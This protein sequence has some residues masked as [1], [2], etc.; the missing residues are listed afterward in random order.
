LTRTGALRQAARTISW[1]ASGPEGYE[2]A[3]EPSPGTKPSPSPQA[4]GATSTKRKNAK[5][6]RLQAVFDEYDA[7]R[8]G[9]LNQR[10]VCR[11]AWTR[12]TYDTRHTLMTY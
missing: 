11:G 1:P 10:E 2:A 8:D 7:D 6:A 4:G 3:Q 5:L 12:V 9:K